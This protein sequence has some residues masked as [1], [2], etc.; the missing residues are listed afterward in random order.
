M[1]FR[2]IN[3]SSDDL[4]TH[5]LHIRTDV[6]VHEQGVDADIEQDEHDKSATH[7]VLYLDGDAVGTGR[8][9]L[10]N[11]KAK[12]E[13]VCI[14]KSSRKKRLRKKTHSTNGIQSQ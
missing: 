4:Y 9:R 2:T 11:S 5:C 10:H 13:R 8:I 1:E 7:I 12:I 6:F 14:L 3:G